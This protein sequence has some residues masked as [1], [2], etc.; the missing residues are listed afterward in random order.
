VVAPGPEYDTIYEGVLRQ[1]DVLLDLAKSC[2]PP[3]LLIDLRHT[4][5]VG[6]AFLGLILRVSNVITVQRHGRLGVCHLTRFC[7]TIFETTKMEMLCE[8]FDTRE[9]AIAAFVPDAFVAP[10][11]AAEPD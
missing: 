3:L 11:S 5:Y 6:S 2:E 7:K 10:A 1:F 4:N 9:E 8:Q